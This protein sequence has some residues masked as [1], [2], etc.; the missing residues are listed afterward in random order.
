[1]FKYKRMTVWLTPQQI[2]RVQ[3]AAKKGKVSCSAVIREM[4]DEPLFS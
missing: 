2:T 4:I 3:K 1:M